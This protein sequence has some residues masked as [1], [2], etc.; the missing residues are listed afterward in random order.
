MLPNSLARRAYL[1]PITFSADGAVT[2]LG[3]YLKSHHKSW[4]YIPATV[5]TVGHAGYA[6]HASQNIH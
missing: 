3:Y 6:I 1:Y 2:Y 4:W 5:L